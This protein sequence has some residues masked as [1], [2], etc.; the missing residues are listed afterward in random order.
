MSLGKPSER[1]Q[2]FDLQ[3]PRLVLKLEAMLRR[4]KGSPRPAA[5]DLEE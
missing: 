4:W 5:A 3:Q 2:W 1:L